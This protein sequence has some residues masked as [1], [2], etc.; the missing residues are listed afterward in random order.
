[1]PL[2]IDHHA[3]FDANPLISWA[4]TRTGHGSQ[5]EKRVAT[6]V[7]DLI[8]SPVVTAISELTL[9]ELHDVMCKKV[10]ETEHHL[11]HLDSAWFD[12]ARNE[13][14]T[15][16]TNT[17]LLVLPTPPKLFERA[18]TLIDMMTRDHQRKFR[19]WDAAHLHLVSEWSR[20]L[21]EPVTLVTSDAD[22]QG[23]LD[24]YPEFRRTVHLL[25]PLTQ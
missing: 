21:G 16:V 13:L 25:D 14:M 10:R 1:M 22:F 3:Y 12:T 17:D 8:T 5:D 4:E 18:I 7:D 2:S 15:L 24:L 20:D 9:I 19:A 6:R 23:M 11:L